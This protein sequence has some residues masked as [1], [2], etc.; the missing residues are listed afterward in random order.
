MC[1]KCS[2]R[3]DVATVAE[4]LLRSDKGNRKEATVSSGAY[5]RRAF[6]LA[7]EEP[8]TVTMAFTLLFLYTATNLVTSY[9]CPFFLSQLKWYLIVFF[10]LFCKRHC[11]VFKVALLTVFR[12]RTRPN[13]YRTSASMFASWPF[14]GFSVQAS[15]LLSRLC[16]ELSLT[17]YGTS[18][19]LIS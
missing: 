2:S 9:H 11:Q 13:S 17:Q 15:I 18:C 19:S 14:R 16:L 8:G 12:I 5:L 4:N 3:E 6:S 7:T 1:L 10:F